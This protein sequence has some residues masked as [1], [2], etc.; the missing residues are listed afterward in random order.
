MQQKNL[1][2]Y[3]LAKLSGLSQSTL[4]NMRQRGTT[5]SIYTIEQICKGLNISLAEFFMDE[6]DGSCALSS[7]QAEL[8]QWTALLPPEK[9]KLVLELVKGLV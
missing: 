8:L 2:Y 1:T 6:S 9:Q 3:K 5:P 4:A 7:F